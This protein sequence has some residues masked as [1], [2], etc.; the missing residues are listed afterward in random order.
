MGRV[1]HDRAEPGPAADALAESLRRDPNQPETRADLVAELLQADR[2]E[3]AADRL[4]EASREAPA[5]SRLLG[6]AARHA[7]VIGE[8]DRAA[9]AGNRHRAA[10]GRA[11]RMGQ[12]VREIAGRPDDPA[13]RVEIGRLSVESGQIDLA[14]RCF[15]AAIELD[16]GH[17][18]ARE[19]LSSLRESSRPDAKRPDWRGCPGS[20]PLACDGSWTTVDG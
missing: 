15:L 1:H 13:L 3:E 4:V 2:V 18:P 14:R 12:L 10:L 7:H 16:P 11:E 17:Q 9:E 5:S 6:L 19:A 8:D 20:F